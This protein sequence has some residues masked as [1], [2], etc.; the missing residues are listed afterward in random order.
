MQSQG[1]GD[2]GAGASDPSYVTDPWA[3]A[4]RDYSPYAVSSSSSSSG[5]WTPRAPDSVADPYGMGVG[6]W[7][8]CGGVG[9]W[10][11]LV[12]V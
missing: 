1:Y 10:R 8:G 12:I 7:Y 11:C 5:W 9:L 3:V 4:A 6:V 2:V